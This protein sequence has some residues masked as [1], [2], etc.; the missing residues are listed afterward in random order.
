M[1]ALVVVQARATDPER[2]QG[3]TGA[4]PLTPAE[5]RRGPRAVRCLADEPGHP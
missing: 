1:I 3:G 5:E 2:L 4:V